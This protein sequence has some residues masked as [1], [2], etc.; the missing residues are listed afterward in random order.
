VHSIVSV[1]SE[2]LGGRT[3]PT[4]IRRG[5]GEQVRLGRGLLALVQVRTFVLALPTVNY[6]MK[7]TVKMWM[8]VPSLVQ[9]AKARESKSGWAGACWHLCRLAH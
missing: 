6:S 7:F 9:S 1:T 5:K 3:F 4:T 8:A 2:D